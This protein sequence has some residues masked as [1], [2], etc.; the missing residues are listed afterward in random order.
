MSDDD[1]INIETC[2]QSHFVCKTVIVLKD[3]VYLPNFICLPAIIQYWA[4]NMN[5]LQIITL[6]VSYVY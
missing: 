6:T 2:S 5:Y 4:I 3:G 1:I